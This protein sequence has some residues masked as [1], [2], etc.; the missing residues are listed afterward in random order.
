MYVQSA[1]AA[2]NRSPM[3]T[4]HFYV[5]SGDGPASHWR[6]DGTV[7][8]ALSQDGEV[9]SGFRLQ[10]TA[11]GN[12]RFRM[13]GSDVVGGGNEQASAVSGSTVAIQQWTHVVGV[14][15]EMAN[16]VKLYVN[17][18]LVSPRPY[19]GDVDTDGEL[20]I[21]RAEN[22]GA[23]SR[24]RAGTIDEV[25][26][27]DSVLTDTEIRSR[28]ESDEVRTG[29]CRFEAENDTTSVPNTVPGGQPATEHGGADYTPGAVGTA[30]RLDGTDDHVVAAEP[31]VRTDLSYSVSTWVRL[32][33]RIP[34]PVALAS[35]NGSSEA[36]FQ[37]GYSGVD[38]DSWDR[39]LRG[40]D[41]ETGSRT[42]TVSSERA[43]GLGVRTHL[44]GVYDARAK[45]ARLF[46]N[47]RRVGRPNSEL[48]GIPRR[49]GSKSVGPNTRAPGARIGRAPWTRSAATVE[50]CTPMRS[51]TSWWRMT[52]DSTPSSWQMI[53]SV[54][55]TIPTGRT[56]F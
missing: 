10:V 7:H 31:V 1:D 24:H 37:L 46:V 40:S 51:A 29:H 44:T 21:G 54:H 50:W 17:G 34:E 19:N 16:E 53:A 25:R 20:A 35:H 32:D 47:G 9:V 26:V 27:Y 3:A 8:T 2:G 23:D 11:D 39:K 18:S 43:P 49:A 33:E 45:A 4:H 22:G 52:S 38:R 28:V 42:V 30:L 36:V 48:H 5:R 6:L 12:W 15:D 55:C 56:E 41:D 13:T 14:H